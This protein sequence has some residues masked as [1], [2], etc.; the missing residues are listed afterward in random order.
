MPDTKRTLIAAVLAAAVLTGAGATAAQAD[1]TKPSSIAATALT[2][3]YKLIAAKAQTKAKAKPKAKHPAAS[4]VVL[5][6]Y[7]GKGNLTHEL[8]ATIHA[9]APHSTIRVKEYFIHDDGHTAHRVVVALRKAH[10]R[11]VHIVILVQRKLGYTSAQWKTFRKSYSFASVHSCAWACTAHPMTKS[12]THSKF[13]TFSNL[14]GKRTSAVLE[15]STNIAQ[16]QLVRTVQSGVLFRN[17]YS[18]Y[19]TFNHEFNVMLSCAMG[20][21]CTT[22]SAPRST[23]LSATTSVVFAPFTG[24]APWTTELVAT[25]A[26]AGCYIY[27]SSLE[28]HDTVLA[29]ALARLKTEGCQVRVMLEHRRADDNA[30]VL[31]PK[32]GRL[33]D[34]FLLVHN[35]S[36]N[37]LYAGSLDY[38]YGAEH[39]NNQ[40]VLVTT[41][42]YLVP[43]YHSWAVK[44][45]SSKHETYWTTTKHSAFS[46]MATVPDTDQEAIDG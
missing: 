19:A 25:H 31:R 9:A 46:S 45:W 8:I 16:Q 34:K 30:D 44:L 10:K 11:H 20:H 35:G 40:Q 2:T 7:F 28:L 5:T 39:H 4:N 13:W 1:A 22:A 12:V 27:L 18:A 23:K 43:R 24:V 21:H 26:K 32:G 38:S 3:G 37:V 6:D 14:S 33:H 29:K 36:R 17:N 15:T 41:S 42:G